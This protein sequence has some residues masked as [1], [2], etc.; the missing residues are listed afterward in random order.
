MI[1]VNLS[2]QTFS[3]SS[4]LPPHPPPHLPCP[5]VG[6][7]TKSH[8]IIGIASVSGENENEKQTN[9]IIIELNGRIE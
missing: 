5:R 6:Q 7:Y 3:P 9:G 1:S 4:V 8:K 2:M